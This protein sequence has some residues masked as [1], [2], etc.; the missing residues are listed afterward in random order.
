MMH[1]GHYQ[2][3]RELL[4]SGLE[5]TLA[6]QF[7]QIEPIFA[8]PWCGWTGWPAPGTGST[9]GSLRWPRARTPPY[10]RRPAPRM[11]GW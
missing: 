8:P 4:D 2:R 9:N 1:W 10:P 5:L 3:A 7:E 6:N 11:C